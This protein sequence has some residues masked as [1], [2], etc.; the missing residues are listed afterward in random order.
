[1]STADSLWAERERDPPS[2][3]FTGAIACGF[4]TETGGSG[5]GGGVGVQAG[6]VS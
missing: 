5:G 2:F 1:M 6:G 3:S 4:I